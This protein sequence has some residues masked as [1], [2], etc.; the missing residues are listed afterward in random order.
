MVVVVVAVPT[1]YQQCNKW[2]NSHHCC[3]CGC[4]CGRRAYCYVPKMCCTVGIVWY[5]SAFSISQENKIRRA[6]NLFQGETKTLQSAYAMD[7]PIAE[8]QNLEYRY[9]VYHSITNLTT[10][11]AQLAARRSH[12][13]KVVNSILTWRK[14]TDKCF[15]NKFRS[16][17]R[18]LVIYLSQPG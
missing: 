18:H 1:A 10:A 2:G 9:I 4:G 13:P 16:T 5:G 12:N 15:Y 3:G 8:S 17:L 11:L 14:Q 6:L 7:T